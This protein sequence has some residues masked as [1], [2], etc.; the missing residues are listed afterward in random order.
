MPRENSFSDSDGRSLTPDLE[1]ELERERDHEMELA[2][3]PVHPTANPRPDLLLSMPSN[4]HSSS[5]V[6]AKSPSIASAKSPR[7]HKTHKSQQRT[8]RPWPT[9]G[10]ATRY[11]TPGD[12]FR[13]TVRKVI[14]MHRTSTMLLRGNVGAEPGVDPRR[15]SA[16]LSY[17][18]LRQKCLI[19][20][21]EYSP[22]RASFGRMTNNEFIKFLENEEAS[23]RE[24]WVKV[25]WINV[26]G[27]SW[28]VVSTL[29]LKYDIHPLALEDLLH[30]HGHARS[31]SDYFAKHLFLRVLCH[32]LGS[33]PISAQKFEGD[34]F[35]PS[36]VSS[37]KTLTNL[38]RSSSPL[39][40]D[41]KLG[42][43][44]D[45]VN[46]D[47]YGDGD[48]LADSDMEEPGK[49]RFGWST[50]INAVDAEAGRG[51]PSSSSPLSS[52]RKRA[53]NALTLDQLKKGS[54]VNVRIAP[55]CIFLF[56]DGTVVSF[57]PDPDLNFTAPIAARIRQRDTTLRTSGDAALLVES[58]LDLVVDAALEVVDEYRANINI[59][60]R[61]ILMKSKVKTVRDLHIMSGDL[62]LHK[63]T[64]GPIKTLLYGLRRYDV[65]RCAA[66]IDTTKEV[67]DQKIVGFMSH[68]S[69]IYLADVHDH[70]EYI[71]SSLDMYA[72][73]AENLINYT[74]N[75]ASYEM[76]E[77]MRRLTLATII[78]LPLTLLTGYFG[79]N[80]S[81][82]WGV[83]THSDLFF[84]EIAIP[85]MI[86]VIP[87]FTW[88]DFVRMA[89]YFRKKVLIRQ[90]K[91]DFK[92]D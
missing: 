68:K 48:G 87:I 90:V 34:S 58:L 56:R 80:F 25:R 70:M 38:P 36:T 12:R 18:H 75:M 5:S 7:S 40:L 17:G 51:K 52:K 84:W 39:P 22:V 26:G 79:M 31:K 46:G 16:Y 9:P 85:V 15:Q 13:A 67:P 24:P 82:Q 72:A 65:D 30:Q 29:A 21:I 35:N 53:A 89:H 54:R 42:I 11:R 66:I 19:D 44:D 78:F 62:I 14:Q 83:Q 55:M 73:M 41:E 1:D 64:M 23:A 63:R 60:E 43:A 20:I 92:H 71:L 50:S 57:H 10:Q 47:G 27:I 86:V 74:F 91:K 77:V 28:D 32:T 88:P 59:L 6:Q 3:S 4:L 76:N 61:Q 45:G 2:S 69:K 8:A 37:S 81:R 33:T 49:R